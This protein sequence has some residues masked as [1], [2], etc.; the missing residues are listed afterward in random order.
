M[1]KK[2]RISEAVGRIYGAHI[3]SVYDK[4]S[5]KYKVPITAGVCIQYLAY[6]SFVTHSMFKGTVEPYDTWKV[7][8]KKFQL[9]A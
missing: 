9:C 7:E 6:S 5:K 8:L 3:P 1:K 4:D 2:K